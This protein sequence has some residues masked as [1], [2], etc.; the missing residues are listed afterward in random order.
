MPAEGFLTAGPAVLR[1][2]LS[3]GNEASMHLEAHDEVRHVVSGTKTE[4]LG[5]NAVGHVLN[6][7]GFQGHQMHDG[8]YV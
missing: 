7:F 8:M 1:K 3:R 4:L 5:P 2:V 6:A